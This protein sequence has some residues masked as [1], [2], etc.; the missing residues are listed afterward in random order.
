MIREVDL[1]SYLPPFLAEYQETN[2]TL[3]AENPEFALVWKA[4]DRV[5]TNEF[6]VTADEYGISRFEKL[7]GIFPSKGEELES[8]RQKVQL[9]WAA[10]LPYTLKHLQEVLASVLGAG[11]FEIDIPQ[12]QE[13]KLYVSLINKTD[14][15]YHMVSSL[16]LN[17]APANLGIDTES[18]SRSKQESRIWVGAAVSEFIEV[19]FEP[20]RTEV[21]F[22]QETAVKA[23]IGVF[24][25]YQ[26]DYRPEGG[27]QWQEQ[28]SQ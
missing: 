2:L 1:V 9:K 10:T 7:L 13:Y 28:S 11:G 26:S 4:A 6:I 5:L 25:Y 8:R 14:E 12:L 19:Q 22:R 27:V 21:N 3:T 15:L 17:W 18:R 20:D 24:E 23:G 16:L